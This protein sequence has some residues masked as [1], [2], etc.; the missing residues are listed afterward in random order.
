MQWE[1]K[2]FKKKRKK[3]KANGTEI[4]MPSIREKISQCKKFI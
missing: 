2:Q 3:K 1:D 4:R